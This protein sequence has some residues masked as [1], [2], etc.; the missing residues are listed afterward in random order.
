MNHQLGITSYTMPTVITISLHTAQLGTAKVSASEWTTTNSGYARIYA[1]TNGTGIG[2]ASWSV[3]AFVSGT[4]V[5]ATNATQVSFP[6]ASGSAYP[7]TLYSV[8]FW[9]NITVGSGNLLFFADLGTSQSIAST[10]IVAFFVSDISF[11]LN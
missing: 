8:G 9:N 5:I 7:I 4:G 10:I 2:S 11:T 6:A 3:A 1:G